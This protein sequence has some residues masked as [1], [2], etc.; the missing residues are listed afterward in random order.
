MTLTM[1]AEFP[2]HRLSR[3][4]LVYVQWRSLKASYE[5]KQQISFNLY[6]VHHFYFYWVIFR[7]KAKTHLGGESF[8]GHCKTTGHIRVKKKPTLSCRLNI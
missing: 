5:G 2:L 6:F 4:S 3:P 8:G 7:I 1:V